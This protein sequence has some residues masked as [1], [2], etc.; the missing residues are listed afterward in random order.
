V[1]QNA[2]Q[3]PFLC[4]STVRYRGRKVLN[5]KTINFSYEGLS[6]KEKNGMRNQPAR[7]V[8]ILGGTRIP[9]CRSYTKYSSCSNLDMMSAVLRAL[10]NNFD[11]K[12]A[13]LDDVSLGAVIKHSRDWNFARES[14]LS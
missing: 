3:D 5:S 14:V 1:Q 7:R 12:G 10:V 4:F 11:L 8:A 6:I 9:F 2:S 13:K